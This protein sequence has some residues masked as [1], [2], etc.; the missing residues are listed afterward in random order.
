MF[1]ANIRLNNCARLV[2]TSYNS[3]HM[4]FWF[5]CASMSWPLKLFDLSVV[6]GFH[7][8]T[9]RLFFVLLVASLGRREGICCLLLMASL[10]RPKLFVFDLWLPLADL[11]IL[12]C[13]ACGFRGRAWRESHFHIMPSFGWSEQNE[14]TLWLKQDF[15]LGKPAAS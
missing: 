9:W 5:S 11:R 13:F 1:M 10:G 2:Q 3:M 15:G 12:F 7:R 4:C 14:G 8:S 6:C